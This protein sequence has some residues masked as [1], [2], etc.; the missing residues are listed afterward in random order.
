MVCGGGEGMENGEAASNAQG[1]EKGVRSTT[2][3]DVRER[4]PAASMLLLQTIVANSLDAGYH[5]AAKA[6]K[7]RLSWPGKVIV[8]AVTVLLSWGATQAALMLRSEDAPAGGV[9]SDLVTQVELAT[10][11]IDVLDEGNTNLASQIRGIEVAQGA[12]ESVPLPLTLAAASSHVSGPGVVVTVS[13]STAITSTKSG[14]VSD[15]NLRLV[16]NLLWQAGAEAMGVNGSRIGPGTSVRTAG[17][18]ILINLKT[19]S[20]PYV[21]EAIGDP[22]ALSEAFY[23]GPLAEKIT[24]L[25]RGT[26]I[27]V[28]VVRSAKLDLAKLSLPSW[29][30]LEKTGQEDGGS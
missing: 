12:I 6:G 19:V 15:S 25:Q 7:P 16:M 4:D 22:G 9:E 24:E 17:A 11:R 8:F 28:N 1:T 27:S 2:N 20:S 29:A 13:D 23:S 26:G 30:L 5:E 18:S 21:I 10:E 3:G 14:T